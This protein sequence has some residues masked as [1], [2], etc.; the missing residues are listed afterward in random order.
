MSRRQIWTQFLDRTE[1]TDEFTG[2]QL[3]KLS[4]IELNGR[5]I[6]NMLKIGGL[7][8]RS[9]KT[10]LGYQHI[11]AVLNLRQSNRHKPTFYI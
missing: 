6:K 8:A 3:D 5:Q 2:A 10:K 11:Q 4:L 9:Q 7:V 1:N